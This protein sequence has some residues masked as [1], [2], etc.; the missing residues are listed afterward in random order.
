MGLVFGFIV[1]VFAGGGLHSDF[2][3]GVYLVDLRF[4]VLVLPCDFPVVV[5]VVWIC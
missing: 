5:W 3:G 1:C 2:V 4:W